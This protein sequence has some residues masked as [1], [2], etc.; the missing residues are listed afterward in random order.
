M[1]SDYT[2]F[3]HCRYRHDIFY[4]AYSLLFVDSSLF[5]VLLTINFNIF[6]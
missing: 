4:K 2:S 1:R 5:E 3:F 6:I